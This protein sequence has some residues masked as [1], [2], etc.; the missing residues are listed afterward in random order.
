MR[1]KEGTALD[2]DDILLV[3]QN[4]FYFLKEYVRDMCIMYVGEHNEKNRRI[5]N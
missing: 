3:P 1:I 2:F 5:Y 4:N